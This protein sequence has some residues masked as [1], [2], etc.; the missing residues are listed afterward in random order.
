MNNHKF[1]SNLGLAMRAG[2]LVTGDTGVLDAIR[3]G[4]AKLVIMALDASPNAQ[5]KYRDKCAHYEVPLTEF[6]TRDQ[7]GAGIGKAERVVIAVIDAGFAQMLVRSQG[8]PAEV[9]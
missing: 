3:S 8:K 5:K 9:E 4:E 1:F 6:G 7:L 2:K